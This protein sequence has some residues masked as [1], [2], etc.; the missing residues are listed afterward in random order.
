MAGE[1]FDDERTG[2]PDEFLSHPKWHR[3]LVAVSGPIH[4]H[5]SGCRHSYFVVHA[6]RI[7]SEVSEGPAIVGPVAAN[8]IANRA[9]LQTGDRIV[10]SMVIR[11]DLGGY[12]NC[13]GNRTQGCSEC[14]SVAQWSDSC[15]CISM[16]LRRESRSIR[17]SWVLSFRF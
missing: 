3:F 1:A 17:R 11:Q 6:R 2:A 4:E 16:R 8:S 12:G 13:T 10:S 5:P 14:R 7:C 15:S 9:G